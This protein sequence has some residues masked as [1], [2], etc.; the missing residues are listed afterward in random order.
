MAGGSEWL[1]V[2][3]SICVETSLQVVCGLILPVQ[4]A[5]SL[6]VGSPPPLHRRVSLSL[7]L[8]VC[9][10]DLGVILIGHLARYTL[11]DPND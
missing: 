5:G 3:L 4:R 9:S 2:I 8:G 6:P 7:G 11:L 10:D 1:C